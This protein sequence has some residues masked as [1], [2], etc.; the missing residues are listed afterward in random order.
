[1]CSSTRRSGATSR[2]EHS[3]EKLAGR[4]LFDPEI[5]TAAGS[6]IRSSYS[7]NRSTRLWF[8]LRFALVHL[9]AVEVER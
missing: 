9:A 6:G 7:A 4:L 1:V 8:V 2:G 5:Q 3:G